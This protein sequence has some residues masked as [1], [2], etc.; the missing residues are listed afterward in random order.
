MKGG[1]T[2]KNVGAD[3]AKILTESQNPP[4]KL[5]PTKRWST[6]KTDS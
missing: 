6:E 5:A 3:L 2:T 1:I 4:A